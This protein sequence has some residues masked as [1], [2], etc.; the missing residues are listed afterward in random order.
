MQKVAAEI[1]DKQRRNEPLIPE[2][3]IIQADSEST[4]IQDE[5]IR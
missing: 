5:T 2:H 4:P 3:R 1:R